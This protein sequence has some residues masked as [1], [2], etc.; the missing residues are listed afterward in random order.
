[1]R[2]IILYS[3]MSLDGFIAREDGNIDWLFSDQDYGYT[4]FEREV[5]TTLMGGS[6]YRTIL[7]FG[8]FPYKGKRNVVFSLNVPPGNHPWV[9]FVTRN[10]P[11]FTAALKNEPGRD[12]WLIGG[13][14]ING[15][16]LSNG[17]IDELILSVHPI[18][19]GNGIPLFRNVTRE[20]SWDLIS[21][22]SFESGLC[23]LR[24][25]LSRGN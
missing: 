15:L 18:V 19:L 16:L 24:Y 25:T 7:G 3:A 4:E 11:A 23:Q 22:D 20:A 17:L 1:M 9:E 14:E 10:I 12:I 2:K 6:T 8:E 13:G 5:D 21:S